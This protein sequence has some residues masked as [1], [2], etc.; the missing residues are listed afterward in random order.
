MRVHHQKQLTDPNV[1][2]EMAMAG[3]ILDISQSH[4]RK[5]MTNQAGQAPCLTT[6]STL[7]HFGRPGMVL[8]FEH[9]L[10]QGHRRTVVIPSCMSQGDIRDLAGEGIALPCLGLILWSLYL[11]KGFP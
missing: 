9:L 4:E 10:F 2:L 3:V 7:Y 1:P 6:S 11:T 5:T 8:P